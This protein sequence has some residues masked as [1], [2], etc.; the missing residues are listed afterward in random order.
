[1]TPFI[2]TILPSS[3]GYSDPIASLVD[4]HSKGVD[5]TWLSKRAAAG[6]FRDV[7]IRPEKDH[8]YI[9]LIAMGDAEFYGLNRNGDGFLKQ[10]RMLTIPNPHDGKTTQVKIHCGNVDTHHTFEK[11][12]KVYR[13]HVNKDPKKAE[14]DV[15]KSAHNDDMNRVELLVRVKNAGWE[16]ELQKLASGEDIP[17]SMSC[18]VPY[19]VC[20]ECGHKAA[21]RADYC[22]HLKHHMGEITKSGN[23]I[24]MMN[25]HMVYFRY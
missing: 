9:H 16:D 6:M 7:D 4:V 23:Q 18:K 25:D 14:G 13:N 17:F 22:D 1:M 8:S 3:F 19:D 2:K 11:V 24:G 12:A 10:G 20:T 15:Y 5:S 21:K